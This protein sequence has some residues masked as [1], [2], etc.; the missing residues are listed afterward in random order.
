[1]RIAHINNVAGVASTIAEYQKK[2]GHTVDIFIFN[3]I[4]YKQFGGIKINYLSPISRWKLLRRLKKDY[5][6]WHYHYPYGS[7]KRRLE[8]Q[9]DGKVYLKHYHGDDIRGKRDD[10]FCLVSSPDL[11]QYTPNG[12]WLPTPINVSLVERIVDVTKEGPK[13]RNKVLLAHYPYYKNNPRNYIDYYSS[14]LRSLQKENKCQ[15]VEIFHGPYTQALEAISSSD[16]VIGK[17]LPNVGWFGKL[18]LEGMALSK[19]VI[20]YVSDEL[21][22]KYK[23]PVY[24]TTKDTFKQ[25]LESLIGNEN[26]IIRLAK[27]GLNYVKKYHSIEVVMKYVDKYYTDHAA[28]TMFTS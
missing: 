19:A 14:T 16:I 24:R 26:E 12:K 15:I 2:Q 11:L 6:V 8:K 4:I 28:E 3:K 17:I 7:L 21:Y 1:M 9:N 5:D 20:S 18:E 23:P 13:K 27:E 10:D 22:E 25:D